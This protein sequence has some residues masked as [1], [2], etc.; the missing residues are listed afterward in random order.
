MIATWMVSLALAAAPATAP[1]GCAQGD[2]SGCM[3]WPEAGVHYGDS[4]AAARLPGVLPDDRAARRERSARA[5]GNDAQAAQALIEQAWLD[6]LGQRTRQ[7]RRGFE[8]ALALPAGDADSRRRRH[9]L[10]AEACARLDDFDCSRAHWW[11]AMSG[12]DTRPS[13]VPLALSYG[14]WSSGDRARALAWYTKAVHANAALGRG[15]HVGTLAAGTP[16]NELARALFLAWAAEHAPLAASL[17][18][19]VRIGPDGRIDRVQLRPHSLQPTLASRVQAAIAGWRFDPVMEDGRPVALDTHLHVDV[20]GRHTADGAA[21]FEVQHSGSGVTA[22]ELP[23]MR[24]PPE[25]LR[26]QVEG[27]VV[28]R[29]EIAADGSVGTTSIHQSSGHAMLDHAA[30]QGVGRYRFHVER[31]DGEG[32]ASAVLLP[33]QFSLGRQRH[34]TLPPY[35]PDSRLRQLQR[36]ATLVF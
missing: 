5:E 34:E 22:A 19:E 28:V 10:Y 26:R 9:W 11:Q 24:Y 14:L 35:F 4:D 12:L 29:A 2:W 13:W 18:A 27:T 7:A 21:T 23:P 33:V 1:D 20:R 6:A 3:G 31:I 16:L 32:R 25:A 15:G 36:P 17:V 8:A 30:R